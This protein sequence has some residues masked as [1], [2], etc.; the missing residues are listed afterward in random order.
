M[1]ERRVD[2]GDGELS[3]T[4]FGPAEAPAV[5]LV[6]G[7]T[8][9]SRAWLAVARHRPELRLVAPDLRGRARSSHLPPSTGLRNHAADLA[10]VIDQLELG[11]VPVIGHSMG[12]FVAVALAAQRPDVVASLV[13][14]DGGLPLERPA[15]D[16]LGPISA[17]LAREFATFEEARE[18]WHAHPAFAGREVPD[19]DTYSDYDLGGEPPHLRPAATAEAIAADALDLYGP[20]WYLEALHGLRGEVPLLRAPRGL[21]DEPGGLYPGLPRHPP[22]VPAV[23]VTDVA[24]TNHAPLNHYTI[25]MT[26]PGAGIVARSLTP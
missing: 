26:D 20:D 16:V 18:F 21:L 24:D 3:V 22:L 6:H 11:A 10:R 2:V 23:T 14:V 1:R 9:S 19:L 12:A 15:G 5:L 13:L 4:E 17:R 25:V 7:I 8:S